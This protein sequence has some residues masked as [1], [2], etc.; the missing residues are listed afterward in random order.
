MVELW[1]GHGALSTWVK[2]AEEGKLTAE[3][4]D[5]KP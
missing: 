3:M 2:A 4:V 1:F 5:P